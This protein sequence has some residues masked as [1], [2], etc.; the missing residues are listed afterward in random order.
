[1]GDKSAKGGGGEKKEFKYELCA[2][3][4]LPKEAS[5][6]ITKDLSED[7]RKF[8]KEKG[9]KLKPLTIEFEGAFD[10]FKDT[11][12]DSYIQIRGFVVA[13]DKFVKKVIKDGKDIKEREY[14]SEYKKIESNAKKKLKSW[15]EKEGGKGGGDDTEALEKANEAMDALNELD[16]KGVFQKPCEAALKAL[17][18]L[19][20]GTPDASAAKKA[21]D[22]LNEAML[23]F[24]NF[25]K[26]AE[27]AIDLLLGNAK[28]IKEDKKATPDMQKFGKDV[29]K[30]EAR[31]KPL[32]DGSKELTKAFE[33]AIKDTESDKVDARS[34]S[35]YYKKFQKL[36]GL[37]KAAQDAISL[38]KKMAPQLKKLTSAAKKKK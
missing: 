12:G 16:P 1:M 2:L 35:E 21:N 14:E 5:G 32:V 22:G 33:D 10:E 26:K 9:I 30:F 17:K 11:I 24:G 34:M 18:P 36:A 31:L 29:L 3:N 25:G 19:T 6:W 8:L 38:A 4:C 27:E 37:E 7:S 20:T 13:F 28:K 23:D 15:A